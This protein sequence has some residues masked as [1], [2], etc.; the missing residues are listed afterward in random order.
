MQNSMG[1]GAQPRWL[2]FS[3]HSNWLFA[4][5]L[6]GAAHEGP[7]LGL[8]AAENGR[9]L[10]AWLTRGMVDTGYATCM[11]RH[12]SGKIEFPVEGA[13]QEIDCPHCGS[14]T[15]LDYTRAKEGAS[16]SAPASGFRA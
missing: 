10:A 7:T 6:T 12:C 11:C 8:T 15:I 16:A 5:R 9:R 2:E 3:G 4:P 14:G 13:G 1:V